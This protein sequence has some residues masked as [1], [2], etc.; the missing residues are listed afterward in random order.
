[1]LPNIDV[2]SIKTRTPQTTPELDEDTRPTQ[3]RKMLLASLIRYVPLARLLARLAPVTSGPY[4]LRPQRAIRNIDCRRLR[5]Q[6]KTGRFDSV[7]TSPG[8]R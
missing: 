1:M 4:S 6:T 5:Q 8:V 2:I 3:G 7:C